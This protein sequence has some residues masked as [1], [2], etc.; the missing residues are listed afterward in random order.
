ME[1]YSQVK[2]QLT[3]VDT[4]LILT[5]YQNFESGYN[6]QHY[7][8]DGAARTNRY[9][10]IT[11]AQ[12]P[13]ALVGWHR[14]WSPG[15]HTM[16]LGGRL[17]GK[18]TLS[19]VGVNQLYLNTNRL[20]Q[21]TGAHSQGFAQTGED[22]GGMDLEYGLNLTIYTAEL[23]QI[24]A[25]PYHTTVFGARYQNGTFDT[26]NL[27]HN[28][29]NLSNP[30]EIYL[31]NG[32]EASRFQEGFERISGYGYHAWEFLPG[33]QVTAGLTYDII[34][35]PANFRH[36]PLTPGQTERNRWSPKAA[37]IW[38]A[39]PWLTVRAI[40][41]QALG[42]V[43]LDESFRLEP[44]QI[45]GFTQG[46]RSVVSESVIS[47]VS[48]PRFDVIGGA[49]DLKFPTYT[50]F[51]VVAEHISS[52]V[53]RDIGVFAGA[54]TGPLGN[55]RP[56]ATSEELDYD[57]TTLRL[58]ANQLLGEAWSVGAA[59]RF[60]H[61]RLRQGLPDIPASVFADA[62]RTESASLHVGGVFALFNHP[63]GFYARADARWFAQSNEG[64]TPA[65]RGD[66]FPQFDVQVGYYF[67]RRRG[68]IALGGFNLSGEDYHL[69][70][71]TYYADLP[72]DRT[73][74]VRFGLA[75]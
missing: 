47:S 22:V 35:F 59:Y 33:I 37:L 39:Q 74:M 42:G 68:Q 64:Y 66:S 56:F 63:S 48:G 52:S 53:E 21:V 58:T 12:H 6:F 14:E 4:L 29:T 28:I 44:V 61:A 18:Q 67:W 43:S 19:D 73:I 72:R 7:D 70:P 17:E 15:I 55:Y 36:P 71:L 38:Q 25:G 46:Y 20:G 45:A 16:V 50:Y 5:K 8:L 30:G 23:N 54:S 27:L 51:G 2:L 9:Y 31:F 57:E 10:R 32:R 24:I 13:L 40:Y 1:W 75:Y 65:L 41:S 11:E 49:F 60:T 62:N 34:R 3:P 26:Y 69:N